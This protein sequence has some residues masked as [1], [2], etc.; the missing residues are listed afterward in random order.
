MPGNSPDADFSLIILIL[1]GGTF[2]AHPVGMLQIVHIAMITS[3]ITALLVGLTW[4]GR[5]IRRFSRWKQSRNPNLDA[6][7]AMTGL[8]FEHCVT[9]LLR[10]Q[11]Y[12]N[13]RQTVQYD[14]GVDIIADKDDIRW[15]IQ[16]K[17]YSGLVGADAVRQVVTALRSY[18]CDMAMVV[19][20]SVY[21][22][23]AEGLARDSDC[24]LI[25]RNE[26]VTW[27]S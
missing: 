11:G 1:I 25:D 16:V 13:I 24:V 2:W 7:D 14:L 17:R 21:S 27:I 3:L 8:E 10:I 19:T 22:R 6:I 4:L 26:L 12:E 5:Q 23:P 15:G 20:N 9:G 18:Q